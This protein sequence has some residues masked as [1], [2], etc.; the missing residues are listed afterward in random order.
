MKLE[1]AFGRKN[2]D[3]VV[4]LVLGILGKNVQ[5]SANSENKLS[6]DLVLATKALFYHFQ[7]TV[8]YIVYMY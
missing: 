4:Y 2:P 3:C 1:R 5:K 6:E 8:L 7:R